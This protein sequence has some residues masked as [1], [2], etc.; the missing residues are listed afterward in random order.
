MAA[1]EW[2]GDSA[3]SIAVSRLPERDRGASAEVTGDFLFMTMKDREYR[4]TASGPGGDAGSMATT[5]RLRCGRRF[6]I[7][8]VDLYR[9]R[10]RR[11]FA[12]RASK[13]TGIDKKLVSKDL[14]ALLL[15]IEERRHACSEEVSGGN[16]APEMPE[17]T[18][19][20]LAA[21]R[22]LV[23]EHRAAGREPCF[24]RRELSERIGCGP[25]QTGVHVGRLLGLGLVS[26]IQCR[27]G[28]E[29]RYEL[30][31]EGGAE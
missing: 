30:D 26:L 12:S 25:T 17:R 8:R 15:A 7:D 22:R 24:T 9:D 4:A 13:E 19:R 18:R 5:L 14:G 16:S 21:A 11:R 6:H 3:A 20:T 10:D 31:G 1:A 23:S 28:R 27:A 2:R 29:Y